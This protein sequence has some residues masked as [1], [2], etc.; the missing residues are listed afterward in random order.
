MS[1]HSL[2]EMVPYLS[3]LKVQLGLV[4]SLVR[5]PSSSVQE[6]GHP[7]EPTSLPCI[8]YPSLH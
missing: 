7:T 3:M 8:R 5:H 2:S 6:K 1:E 4:E